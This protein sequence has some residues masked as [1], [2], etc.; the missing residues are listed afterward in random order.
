[1]PSSHLHQ[2]NEIM[3]LIVLT[4]PKS[5]L[6]VGVGFGKYGFLSRE[7]LD[8]WDGYTS[9]K[10]RIDGIEVFKEY[11]TPVHDFI[12]D[13]IYVGTAIDILPTLKTKYDLILLI[14]IL[15][16]FDYEDGIKL[17]EYCNK[18][19]RNIIISTPKDI[20][21]QKEFLGNPFETHRFQWKKKDFDKLVNKFYMPNVYSLICYIG[22]DARKVSKGLLMSRIKSK[23]KKHFPFLRT[24]PLTR[25]IIRTRLMIRWK[26]LFSGWV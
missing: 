22:T 2:L 5:I 12:Y 11:L 3:K 1:M 13:N 14:D 9:W 10:R 20:S 23:I 8:I 6:D 25:V 15:E 7:Y 21:D 24:C 26:K 4:D 17:L 18:R 19:A 16:H